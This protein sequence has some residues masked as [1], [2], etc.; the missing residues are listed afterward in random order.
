MSGAGVGLRAGRSKSAP[1]G[2]EQSG[3]GVGRGGARSAPA[4]DK[5]SG[6]GVGR[7]GEGA[8]S[9][10]EEKGRR[11]RRAGRAAA[12]AQTLDAAPPLAN[13]RGDGKGFLPSRTRDSSPIRTRTNEIMP[14]KFNTNLCFPFTA[15]RIDRARARKPSFETH[16]EDHHQWR[17]KMTRSRRAPT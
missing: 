16:D 11:R 17:K 13:A 4:G 2:E 1:V 5:Q 14:N 8:A 6:A 12:G 9:G 7:G 3:A 10:G 15:T